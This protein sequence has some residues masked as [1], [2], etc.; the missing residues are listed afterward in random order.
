VL[1]RSSPAAAW[2]GNSSR[3]DCA[4]RSRAGQFVQDDL[5]PFDRLE[6]EE[7]LEGR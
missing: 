5:K 3:L 1:A 2:E 4:H 6:A 7:A